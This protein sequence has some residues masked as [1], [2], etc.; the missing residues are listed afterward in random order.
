MSGITPC[1]ELPIFTLHL[2]NSQEM[3]WY[4]TCSYI[5][6]RERDIKESLKQEVGEMVVREMEMHKDI[7]KHDESLLTNCNR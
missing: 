2:K 1:L 6:V 5:V 4:K 3:G 7:L